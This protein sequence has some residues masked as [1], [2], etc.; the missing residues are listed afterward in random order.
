MITILIT[1]PNLQWHSK[2]MTKI[3]Y[4]LGILV[5]IFILVS[6][7]HYFPFDLSKK[8]A[9]T[10]RNIS[11][12]TREYTPKPIKLKKKPIA[13]QLTSEYAGQE[14]VKGK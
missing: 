8:A 4:F 1:G 10:S 14:M 11:L 13:P 9:F 6:A 7:N 3:K 5:I 12:N 2:I